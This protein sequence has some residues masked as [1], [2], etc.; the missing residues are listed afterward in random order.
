MRKITI[1]ETITLLDKLLEIIKGKCNDTTPDRYLAIY[2]LIRKIRACMTALIP[3]KTYDILCVPVNL[4]YRCMIAD[5]LTSLLIIMID[6]ECFDKVMYIMDY[7]Y[8][9]SLKKALNAEINAKKDLYL[10][11]ANEFEQLSLDYQKKHYDFFVDY[12]HSQP[13]EEWIFNKKPNVNIQGVKFDGSVDSIYKI[14]IN[15]QDVKY[16]ASV[17]EYYKLFSQSEHYSLKNRIFIYKQD[18]HENYYNK[19]R[20]FIYLG[21]K[22][23]YD[24]LL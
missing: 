4:L 1:T 7:H 13:G 14:L 9:K 10:D 6:E 19:T 5:L 3:I 8:A 18:F 20:G 21:V 11:D 2:D 22:Y 24:N 15:Y 17:Y 12:L 23:I 16:I